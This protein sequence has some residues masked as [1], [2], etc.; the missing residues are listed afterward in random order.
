MP[1]VDLLAAEETVENMETN[2]GRRTT[3]MG[4]LVFTDQGGGG[5]I[6]MGKCKKHANVLYFFSC[7]PCLFCF[8]LPCMLCIAPNGLSVIIY[9]CATF[10]LLFFF[11][12][13]M[14][15]ISVKL[16]GFFFIFFF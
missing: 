6:A 13:P 16:R 10:F 5:I 11:N 14:P 1:T 9:Y 7:L 12:C 2:I 8:A 4:R 3:L 15:D